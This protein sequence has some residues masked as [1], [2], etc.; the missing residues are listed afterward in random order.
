MTTPYESPEVALLVLRAAAKLF[1]LY[2][3]NGV[4]RWRQLTECPIPDVVRWQGYFCSVLRCWYV[5]MTDWPVP[6]RWARVLLPM[7]WRLFSGQSKT[8]VLTGRAR[9]G[10]RAGV[11]MFIATASAKKRVGRNSPRLP[12]RIE[13][14]GTSGHGRSYW[15]ELSR[16]VFVPI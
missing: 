9:S 3:R 4:G 1:A 7:S 15:E 16:Q 5:V 14:C 6:C 2:V 13:L 12:P 11:A 10:A 8:D